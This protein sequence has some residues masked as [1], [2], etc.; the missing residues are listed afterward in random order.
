M[1]CV[2]PAPMPPVPNVMLPS[3]NVPGAGA[4]SV[5]S[6]IGGTATSK[7]QSTSGQGGIVFL[8]PGANSD[9]L[10]AAGPSGLADY[11][12]KVGNDWCT[13]NPASCGTGASFVNPSV[14]A[15]NW[16][17]KL[18]AWLK[19]APAC[20]YVAG[21][22]GSVYDNWGKPLDPYAC[23]PGQSFDPNRGTCLPP[24]CAPGYNR[25]SNAAPCQPI[26]ASGEQATPGKTQGTAAQGSVPVQTKPSNY[27]S[28]SSITTNNGG[29]SPVAQNG[30]TNQQT[31]FV[32]A[33]LIP[34][35]TL[36]TMM[37]AQYGFSLAVPAD[38]C[39]MMT[40]ALGT[41]FS[42]P[43]LSLNPSAPI[44]AYTFLAALRQVE[45]AQSAAPAI[46]QGGFLTQTAGAPAPTPTIN[47]GVVPA[48]STSPAASG[49]SPVA[50]FAAVAVIAVILLAKRG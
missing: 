3:G 11:L 30:P 10:V 18:V 40:L 2:A 46:T 43:N 6:V 24:D 48:T 49:L 28:G 16:A 38:W 33:N 23:P 20:A 4:V 21:M 1:N 34:A 7:T 13:M 42:C 39:R 22:T 15:I 9:P 19:A 32:S 44:D 31:P 47:T 35:S 45:S 26:P 14:S 17:A 50:I 29:T 8:S 36:A 27:G 25:E 5:D 37:Q 12:T 41:S